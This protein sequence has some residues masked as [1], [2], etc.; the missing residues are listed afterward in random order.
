MNQNPGQDNFN[1]LIGQNGNKGNDESMI[2][3][4]RSGYSMSIV[5]SVGMSSLS[6]QS[7]DNLSNRRGEI[8]ILVNSLVYVH[9]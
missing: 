5:Q 9:T 3:E 7:E 1:T 2:E 4:S 8:D 6:S